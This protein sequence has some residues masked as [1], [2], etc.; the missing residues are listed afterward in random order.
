MCFIFSLF[1]ICFYF[2]RIQ[3]SV[4]LSTLLLIKKQINIYSKNGATMNCFLYYHSSIFLKLLPYFHFIT[5]DLVLQFLWELL[6]NCINCRTFFPVNHSDSHL[7]SLACV[8]LSKTSIALYFTSTE[9]KWK[10]YVL[11]LVFLELNVVEVA[12]NEA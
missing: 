5:R 2:T 9:V 8:S 6:S 7:W 4:F 12:F 11:P 3:A 10:R 1:F